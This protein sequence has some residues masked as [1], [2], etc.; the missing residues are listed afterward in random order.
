MGE[1]SGI[2]SWL[3]VHKIVLTGGLPPP[4]PLAVP[5]HGLFVGIRDFG[6]DGPFV[7]QTCCR[8]LLGQEGFENDREL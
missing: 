3:W 1:K 7:H 5:G 8:P 6:S 4:R 2:W